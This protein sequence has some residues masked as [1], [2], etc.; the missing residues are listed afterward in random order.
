M[1]IAAVAVSAGCASNNSN[2]VSAKAARE[3]EQ[4][5][6]AL[7]IAAKGSSITQVKAA[8]QV[9]ANEVEDLVKSN[10]LGQQR[11]AKIENAAASLVKDFTQRNKPT[12]PPTPT[13]TPTLTP[14]PT[15]PTPTVTVTASPTET[16]SSTATATATSTKTKGNGN[17]NGNGGGGGGGNGD[18]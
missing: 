6:Q 13:F 4:P 8:Q 7:R 10:D 5:V 2:P 16:E 11:A 15:T 14:T 18:G 9:L 3:L 12:P 1:A 17:G